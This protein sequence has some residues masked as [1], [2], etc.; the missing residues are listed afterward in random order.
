MVFLPRKEG[1]PVLIMQLLGEEW[2]GWPN[3]NAFTGKKDIRLDEIFPRIRRVVY[4]DIPGGLDT[5]QNMMPL[6]GKE[7][8]VHSIIYSPGKEL[9]PFEENAS[10]NKKYGWASAIRLSLFQVRK[11]W[12]SL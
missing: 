3:E 4:L 6:P 1:L 5:T 10:T 11:G 12:P 2:S 7:R 8:L 9:G